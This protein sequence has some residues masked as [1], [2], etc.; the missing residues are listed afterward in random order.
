MNGNTAIFYDIENLLKGYNSSK[1][2]ISSI[3]LKAIFDEIQKIPEV[4]RII[5]QKAYA[6]WSDPRLSIMKREINELGIDPIQIF[7]FSHYQK[8][9]AA[10]IQIAVDA[11]DL[12]YV[13]NSIDIFVI[14]SGDGGFSAVAKKLH[15]YA[16]YVVGCGYKSSTNQIF[17]SVCDYFIGIDEPE[18]LEEHQSEIGKNLKI[19]NPIVLRMSESIQRLSSQDRNEM[20]QQSKHILNWFT[21]DGET[22]KELAKLGI[23]LSV[24]KE[25]FKYGIEDFNSAKIGLSKFV[26]FLQ[27]ICN[28]TNLKVVTSSKCETKIAFKNNNIKDFE[29]LPYLDPDF[30]HSSENYQSILATGNPR[31]KLINSQ[32]FLK[33][34]SVI[35]SLDDQKQSL[36]SL[37]EYI[38]HLYADIE[39]ENI[40]M[41]LSSLIN[42]NIFEMSEQFLILKPEYVDSQMIINRFKEAVYAKLAS[43]WEA[44]L[45]PEVVEKIISDLLG[46]RP[47]KD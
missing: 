17:E 22:A 33:I 10:D 44:D 43:F 4:G 30:L 5:V 47:Q 8:K 18:D 12:A 6:N 21:Q 32:D 1:N 29:T 11:I 42:I 46:D 45:K 15:E 37:L 28:E 9:N 2:Y 36:D 14:V 41:C 38:N 27:L 34:V 40:N 23:H 35:S 26:H 7:G 24:I 16:K 3:S 31:I 20:I 19:T 39:S 13:R 25:A